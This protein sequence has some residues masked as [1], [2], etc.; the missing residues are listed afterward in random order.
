MHVRISL[1][2]FCE[3]PLSITKEKW[4]HWGQLFCICFC[5][6][7]LGGNIKAQNNFTIQLGDESMPLNQLVIC[8]DA[9][10]QKVLIKLAESNSTPLTNIT[11][12]LHLF[13]GVEFTQLNELESTAGVAIAD[14]SNTNQP[15]ITIPNLASN[16]LTEILLV[17]SVKANCVILDTLNS[18]NSN[19]KILDRWEINYDEGGSRQQEFLDGIE[20]K[21]ALATPNLNISVDPISIPSRTGDEIKRSFKVTNSGLNSYLNALKYQI[22]LEPGMYYKSLKVNGIEVDFEK[23]ITTNNDSLI[24]ID[25]SGDYFIHNT[26]EFG[27]PSNGDRRFDV[28]EVIN[29]EEVIEVVSC[30]KNNDSRLASIHQLSWNCGDTAC[31]EETKNTSIPIGVGEELI[32]FSFDEG[33]IDAGF[34]DEGSLQITIANNG[35]EFD[36]GF[37]SIFNIAT[38]IG[39]V[40]GNDFLIED[41]AYRIRSLNIAGREVSISSTGLLDLNNNA[42][43]NTDPDGAGG[44]EDLDGDGFFDDLRVGQ[45]FKI[46]ATFDLNCSAINFLHIADNCDN[47]LR[48]NI[49]AKITYSNSCSKTNEKLFDNFY[50]S[51]NTGN[52]IEICSDPDAFNDKD[53][54]TISYAAE[55][56]MF[57]F[58]R[59]CTGDDE[60]RI[61]FTLPENIVV[62]NKTNLDQE[63]RLQQPTIQTNGQE[64]QLTFSADSVSLNND[65]TLNFIFETRCAAFGPTSFPMELSYFCP[66]CTCNH[67]WYCGVLEGPVLHAAGAPCSEYIC[68]KGIQTVDFEVERISFGYAD[69]SFST[70]FDPAEANKKVAL[71]CDSVVMK[72]K[73]VVGDQV[74]TDSIDLIIN[75]GNANE[76]ES[77]I[78]TF[79]LSF[80]ELQIISGNAI[81]TCNLDQS[82]LTI[83]KTPNNKVLKFRIDK[84]LNGITL[85]PRDSLILTGHFAVN[86]EAPLPTNTFKKVPSF[87]AKASTVF[88]GKTYECDSYGTLFRLGKMLTTFSG[89]SNTN[90]PQGCRT[91]TLTYTLN[92]TIN[93]NAMRTFFGEEYR[94]AVKVDSLKFTFEP[95]LINAFGD[96][97]VDFRIQ[98]GIWEP[99]PPLSQSPS[100]I[101]TAGFSFLSTTSTINGSNQLFQVRINLTPSCSSAFGSTI[102]DALYEIE[103]KIN[104]KDNYYAG[105][106]GNE[107]CVE[108]KEVVDKRHVD[109]RNTPE[110]SLE[111][112]EEDIE[113]PSQRIEWIVE[114]CNVSFDADANITWLEIEKREGDVEILMIENI[115]D[116]NAIDTLDLKTYGANNQIFA[117]TDGLSRKINNG[118]RTSI[119]NLLRITAN[120]N[121]CG[122]N[123]IAARFGWN[124]APYENTWT[125]ALYPPCEQESIL[126]KARPLQPLLSSKFEEDKASISRFY[127][128]TST[129]VIVLRNEE[130]GFAYDIQTQIILPTGAILVPGSVEFAYPSNSAFKTVNA[131]P[132][133]VEESELGRVFQ[134]NNFS[135]LNI[136]LHENGLPGFNVNA[137]DSSEFRIK[138]SFITDCNFRN[139]AQ[140]HYSF[141]GRNACGELTNRTFAETQPI[142]F[143]ATPDIAR[144]FDI[145]FTAEKDLKEGEN[146]TVNINITN[147]SSNATNIDT[148]VVALPQKL[149]YVNNSRSGTAPVNWL[150]TEPII[151]QDAAA[152]ILKWA[153]PQGLA[154]QQ[155]A[156]LQFQLVGTGLDCDSTYA[157]NINTNSTIV[158]DCSFNS[159][160]CSKAFLSSNSPI[161]NME[162]DCSEPNC[163]SRIGNDTIS[164]LVPNCD[165]S[166]FF[167]INEYTLD[168]LDQ[169]NITDNG[170]LV[171]TSNISVCNY[172]QLCIYTYA[173]INNIAGPIRIDSWVVDGVTYSGTVNDIQELVDSM[174]V[175]DVGGNWTILPEVLILQGGHLDKSYSQMEIT[176]PNKGIRS[177]LGY[178]TRLTPRGLSVDLNLGYHEL[179][180]TDTF[181]CKDTAYISVVQ[182]D[183]PSCVPPTI[184][185]IQ[186]EN[187]LCDSEK[188]K[189]SILLKEEE[190]DYTFEWTPNRGAIGAG[191]HSRTQL[192]PGNYQVKII[193]KQ[194]VDC[195][196]TVSIDI[197]NADGPVATATTTAATCN[198][199]DG[200]IVLSPNNFTYTWNDGHIGGNRGNL[201]S[202]TYI[203]TISDPSNPSCT[204]VLNVEVEEKSSL[205][206]GHTV[207]QKPTCQNNI[208]EVRLEVSGGSGIYSSTFPSGT[209]SQ[210]HLSGGSYRVIIT[211]VNTGCEAPYLF[212]LKDEI[213]GGAINIESVNHLKCLELDNGSVDYNI[214]YETGFRFPSDTFITNGIRLFENGQLP[215]GDFQ[216]YIEDGNGCISGVAPFEIGQPDPFEVAVSIN[217]PCAI[218]QTIHLSVMGGKSPYT[219]KWKDL[220]ETLTMGTREVPNA[221][222]YEVV[223]TD[224]NNCEVLLPVVVEACPCIPTAF[225]DT[226]ITAST[227]GLSNGSVEIIL[228]DPNKQY[229]YN[230]SPNAGT[231]G[232]NVNKRENLAGG[233]YQITMT[234]IE[235]PSCVYTLEVVVP[236]VLP[237]IEAVIFPSSC[238]D[239]PT[240]AVALSPANY[241]YT[242]PDGFVGNNRDLLAEGSYNVTF[243]NANK[244]SCRG[245]YLVE[246]G[247]TNRLVAEVIINKQP[248]CREANGS[249]SLNVTGGT[250]V[251][252]YSWDSDNNR[253]DDL[254]AGNYSVTIFDADLGCQV[255]TEFELISN[256]PQEVNIVI[257]D[258]IPISCIG[259]VDGRVEFTLN[260][261]GGLNFP[262][263]TIIKQ[264]EQV[265]ENGQL[266]PGDYC[267][268]IRDTFNC[269]NGQACF[270]ISMPA[271]IMVMFETEAACADSGSIKLDIT[272]GTAPYTVDWLDIEGADNQQD[273]FLL[274][275][276][277][278]EAVIMD[279]NNCIDSISVFVPECDACHL[280]T[281]TNIQLTPSACTGNTGSIFIEMEEDE[282][283]YD[284]FYMP[285]VGQPFV[286]GNIRAGLP[287]GDYRILIIY[288]PNPTCVIEVE[289][290]IIEKNFD[291]IIPTTSPADCG[292]ANGR[293]VLE[294]ATYIYT[295][296][297]GFIGN[298]RSDLAAGYYQV[299]VRDE[300]HDCNTE[301]VVVVNENNLLRGKAA[302]N[303]HPSCDDKNGS[304]TIN[305]SGGSGD[306]SYSWGNSPTKEDL[307][308]G[309][310]TV[311]VT[312][313]R[314]SCKIPVVFSLTNFENPLVQVVI[315]GVENTSCPLD[316][317]GRVNFTTNLGNTIG[318]Q[319]D[320]II[321]NGQT[322][323]TNGQLP[324]GDYC[325]SIVDTL[326]CVFGQGCFTI[327]SPDFLEAS[328][329]II[330]ECEDGGSVTIQTKGGVAPYKYDWADIEG[331]DNEGNRTELSA[332]FYRLTVS[333]VNGCQVVFDTVRVEECEPCPLK[334]GKDTL[335]YNLEDCAAN[336]D[337]C[338]DYDLNQ[339]RLFNVT[340]DGADLDLLNINACYTDTLD[341]YS[342]ATLFGEG[343]LGPYTVTSWPVNDK[344][345]TGDF[346]SLEVLLDSMNV[347]DP[348]GNW[349]F[350]DKGPYI[351]GGAMGN[352]Y[353]QIDATVQGTP[354][355]SFLE[356]RV[357]IL[358]KGL[359]F[360]LG[361][362][363]HEVTI[364]DPK[365]FCQDTL[366]LVVA[367]TKNDTIHVTSKPERSDSFCL[368]TSELIGNFD[369]IYVA[370]KEDTKVEVSTLTDSCV[371]LTTRETGKE[372]FCVIVCDDLGVCDTTTFVVNIVYD[373]VVDTVTVY[374]PHTFCLDSAGLVLKGE[375]QTIRQI[376]ISNDSVINI[377]IDTVNKCI[378]YIGKVIGSDTALVQVCDDL[379]TCDTL[380]FMITVENNPPDSIKDT[381]FISETQIY[382]FDTKVFPSKIIFFENICSEK[383]GE[384]VDF[385]LDPNNHCIEYS[386]N[387]IGREEACI[388]ICDENNN[389]DTVFFDVEV[390]E[391]GEL[392]V[393]VDDV[394]TT[395]R[396][397]PVILDVMEND[398]PFGVGEGGLTI[399]DDPMFGEI[400]LNSDGSITYIAD[401]YCE[402]GDQ[403]SYS[404][405][406][407]KGCDTAVVSIYVRCVDIEIFTALSPNQDGIN[408]VFF[409][410]GIEE[411]PK[412]ELTIYNR[413]GN[414]VY[415][416]VNYQ[417]DWAGTWKGS[418]ELPDGTYFYRLNLNDENDNRMFEGF[419]E[420]HR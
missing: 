12:R 405:C 306:Y 237:T 308:S 196:K 55:R 166:I 267:L 85:N 234:E 288:K 373:E 66:E 339:E 32:E 231:I 270:T 135:A 11:A 293:A 200:G 280:P 46:Q 25:I 98:S 35:F 279:K 88:E 132:T 305:V 301:M 39:F 71:A 151:L 358:Q 297:D 6:I 378:D 218:T 273:R 233:S 69:A 213:H 302:I 181:G 389:C 41:G 129:M 48:G 8:G 407:D 154:N 174:S 102:G 307:P 173:Q 211:D 351:E 399:V 377:T 212:V 238:L 271:P 247:A 36:D 5:L 2:S 204:N 285:D 189:A 63:G 398:V 170:K 141:Q 224:S 262:M 240:G 194:D 409:I 319:L 404:L 223:I 53:E 186:T 264:G 178:D 292:N 205:T 207:L 376:S 161:F 183:C 68:E 26:K 261:T 14:L 295:W 250:G 229:T 187:T 345:F 27:L 245:E 65:Y 42:I 126:L 393:A 349:K 96:L 397:I 327:G 109:Y 50:R 243:T 21:D 87:R 1:N 216:L 97:S 214:I 230:W 75:Y 381:I 236:E 180:I 367:C 159:E 344:V 323:F 33:A 47:D 348:M 158:F 13:K 100:G 383:S 257:T 34:C 242:W 413:W 310:H 374:E 281:V 411:F 172:Q 117:F 369:S 95:A 3:F 283:N 420:L 391:F 145:Q 228:T 380:E 144:V 416:V 107:A 269:L 22:I 115:S 29:I 360:K 346:N 24:L 300:Q 30:G 15:L 84:C 363:L 340:L 54:F 350:S 320:T 57:N 352:K 148:L 253:S 263:D 121:N 164:V 91:S 160:S 314:T 197:L 387:S 396:G 401:Q 28:D 123:A 118:D 188:G 152:T 176:F 364:Q 206:I 7:C 104:Y 31:Q 134:Y 94:Q 379:G 137:P 226:V 317:N 289:A 332:G 366:I 217:E 386:G 157:L 341:L 74:L 198:A 315:N 359:S 286:T 52:T 246:V 70:P 192:P 254:A 239:P 86:N 219:Y 113:S 9:A 37:A 296:Q 62:S 291:D 294:P 371:L 235:S 81:R 101:Y 370:C 357:Q 111:G 80:A 265:F 127:C 112:I 362:G 76:Q 162:V 195:F 60:I 298:T 354:I 342:Y 203:I 325:L 395:D 326:N 287:V 10:Q 51:S 58:D 410:S 388:V 92:K 268:E 182:Q 313:N 402:R 403:F 4:K 337:I 155:T 365:T 331:A 249:V 419:I 244:A 201:V 73:N 122:E 318:H 333:D 120:I 259:S 184:K 179:V 19:L 128:D 406:N 304:V 272:G 400:H 276:G 372:D 309:T 163:L 347:W 312:D 282:R 343:R 290:T 191:A 215:A 368:S 114:H 77:E 17:F 45:S 417:N 165:T 275:T 209:L 382:C 131:A 338:L 82:D 79:L 133:F 278:Y 241:T 185:S 59:S 16:N 61:N 385:F 353:G 260:A 89:P 324:Q 255:T 43:F 156:N 171:D 334:V 303:R 83:E 415:K 108:A 147:T 252:S 93:A 274:D 38:G 375:V 143:Q 412:S 153:L 330:P 394:D 220:N 99:L 177:F 193:N 390:V 335:I 130:Q 78:E 329:D 49:D 146:R 116:A 190:A 408:D 321:S 355:N 18:N 150:P 221:G 56:R 105:L 103:T 110:F 316:A 248:T 414:L 64:V 168:E 125:P 167:C 20:Y 210:K 169:F 67:I 256:E 336:L 72:M 258:T 322:N 251:Y 208:G 311:L 199:A 138:Y 277:T 142:I 44:L 23:K 392:P 266:P 328:L 418:Q 232:D 175:W 225:T 284:F 139:G 356:Y 136:F 222:D 384:S 140:N 90:Y 361:K 149:N 299:R 202:G 40:E 119:C 124:C 227:C 106:A